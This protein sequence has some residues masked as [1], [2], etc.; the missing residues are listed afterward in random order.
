MIDGTYWILCDREIICIFSFSFSDAGF[1]FPV[2]QWNA[3]LIFF[4]VCVC[5]VHSNISEM[6]IRCDDWW[7]WWNWATFLTEKKQQ[8]F[9][10][11]FLLFLLEALVYKSITETAHRTTHL[12]L[13]T[14]HIRK[15]N[16][17]FKIFTSWIF[18]FQR[19][20]FQVNE[21]IFFFSS[22]LNS[23]RSEMEMQSKMGLEWLHSCIPSDCWNQKKFK[24]KM[25]FDRWKS[26][27]RDWRIGSSRNTYTFC[28]YDRWQYRIWDTSLFCT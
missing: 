28:L 10:P 5:V 15:S 3:S 21:I 6:L 25:I 11:F 19:S 17:F 1:F 27:K 13:F 8:Q 14:W 23:S 22:F 9:P 20:I 2:R 26:V 16:H 7:L 12:V 4:C 18:F 24:K